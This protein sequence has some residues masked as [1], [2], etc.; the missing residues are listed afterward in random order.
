MNTS[1]HD[2]G[3]TNDSSLLYLEPEVPGAYVLASRIQKIA[4]PIIVT[5]GFFGNVFSAT[6]FL[7][8][9][10]RKVSC[11]LY[12][13][14][15]CFFDTGFLLS[16][17]IVW[18]D[19]VG[20]TAFHTQV[21]CQLVI[22][23]TY[24]CGCLSAWMVVMITFENY[25]RICRPFS[26]NIYCTTNKAIVVIVAVTIAAFVFY[27]FPLWT[28]AVQLN[29]QTGKLA[30]LP[31]VK[32]ATINQV[33]T[34]ADTV[35]TLALP[36]ILIVSLM[37][38]IIYRLLQSYHRRARLQGKTTERTVRRNNPQSQVTKLL[39]AI[40]AIFI[41]LTLPSH[42]LRIKMTVVA[43][44]SEKYRQDYIEYA[45]HL[46]LQTLYY[47]SFSVNIIVYTIFGK[48]FRKVYFE[49]YFLWFLK[50]INKSEALI[51]RD[52][53][54]NEKSV[55]MY[56]NDNVEEIQTCTVYFQ[57]NNSRKCLTT[58]L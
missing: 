35:I 30:C 47:F 25:I 53:G 2:D 57:S 7:S 36:I 12:I 37:T 27:N 17:F 20:I 29:T 3:I 19:D 4:V 26:V 43:F 55:A 6:I 56:T 44:A 34:Y 14:A 51:Q 1:T 5:F 22:F 39:F 46:F 13:A 23:F 10:Q 11:S 18:L 28:T 50:R 54:N 8:K 40:S 58:D 45:V 42:V 38:A 31:I 41:T 48:T 24:I 21:L 9:N 52:T 49:I 15:R 16:L 33:V 32:H